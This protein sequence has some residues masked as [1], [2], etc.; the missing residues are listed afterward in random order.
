MRSV[1]E[2]N[3]AWALGDFTFCLC[4]VYQGAHMATLLF[5]RMWRTNR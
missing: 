1:S 5:Q 2:L 3:S 4:E